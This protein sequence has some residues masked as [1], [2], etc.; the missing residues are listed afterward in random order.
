MFDFEIFNR[1]PLL[2][3]VIPIVKLWCDKGKNDRN[4]D[5]ETKGWSECGVGHP[6]GR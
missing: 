4:Q 1:A 6:G 2:V 5:Y 3:M